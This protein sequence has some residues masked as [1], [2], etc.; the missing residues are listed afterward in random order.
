MKQGEGWMR[1]WGSAGEARGWAG[2]G[3][4]VGIEKQWERGQ[5]QAMGEWRDGGEMGWARNRVGLG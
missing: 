4:R 3:G 1:R 5:L 2:W